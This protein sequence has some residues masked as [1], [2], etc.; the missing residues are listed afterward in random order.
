MD[1]LLTRSIDCGSSVNMRDHPK[2]S[3]SA[4]PDNGESLAD[5]ENYINSFPRRDTA[6]CITEGKKAQEKLLNSS[7]KDG[8]SAYGSEY[9]LDRSQF[10]EKKDTPKKVTTLG[11]VGGRSDMAEVGDVWVKRRAR[12]LPKVP[13][14][15]GCCKMSKTKMWTI[16]LVAIILGLVIPV[17]RM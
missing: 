11:S 15:T 1:K 8:D 6:V 10:L 16:I 9:K 7:P 3:D 12:Q 2:Y 5:F 13:E 17:S 4:Q 14:P